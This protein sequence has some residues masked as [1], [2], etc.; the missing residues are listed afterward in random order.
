MCEMITMRMMSNTSLTSIPDHIVT[1]G[2]NSPQNGGTHTITDT[3]MMKIECKNFTKMYNGTNFVLG[4][5]YPAY[6]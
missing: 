1:P 2:V 5:M 4:F 6:Q 3:G